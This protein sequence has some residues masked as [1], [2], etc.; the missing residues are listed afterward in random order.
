VRGEDAEGK[1][2]NELL[3]Q[4]RHYCH[5]G[6]IDKALA[7]EHALYVKYVQP[8]ESEDHYYQCFRQWQAA[9]EDAAAR[10]SW[11]PAQGPVTGFILHSDA[12]MAHTK[13]VLQACELR[14]K[15]LEAV[16][17]VLAEDTGNLRKAFAQYGV[18][19][20]Y[21]R[22]GGEGVSVL[23]YRLR[24]LA[25]GARVGTLVWVSLPMWCAYAFATRLASR[26][27]FWSQR[28]HPLIS[29][30]ID[31]YIC[32]GK[33]SETTRTYHGQTWQVVHTPLA[34][35]IGGASSGTAPAMNHFSPKFGT[36]GRSEK[37]A[38][39]EFLAA[40]M[41]IVQ[42]VPGAGFY[43]T[44]RQPLKVVEQTLH[45][46]PNQYVGWV[47]PQAYISKLDVYLETLRLGGLSTATAWECG[48]P[49]VAL[50]NVHSTYG[51]IEHP[52]L[53]SAATVDEYVAMAVRLAKDSA[54][55][56]AVVKAQNEALAEEIT[57]AG[58]DVCKFW[59]VA[60]G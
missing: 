14:P 10:H 38:V 25:K 34:I 55:R 39:P 60:T 35:D 33:R 53:A 27:V 30:Y 9:F 42:D 8:V 11:E 13:V 12:L 43:W 56:A 19:V 31:R 36:V 49:A 26:Q 44:G 29:P 41:R 47:D 48:V 59:E 23:L 15:G 4:L 54:Y 40:A 57:R 2:M 24:E 28:F 45:A 1:S 20:Y 5:T 50:N 17:F 16:I 22:R 37:I 52:G 46:T 21:L 3:E 32:P 18:K 58:E 7:I 51:G 6:E